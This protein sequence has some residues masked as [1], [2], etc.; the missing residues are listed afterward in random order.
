M[1]ANWPHSAQKYRAV[2][3]FLDIRFTPS[4]RRDRLAD[5]SGQNNDGQNIGQ[6]V[7][8]LEK[9]PGFN[10]FVI[11]ADQFRVIICQHYVLPERSLM[12][13]PGYDT[14][15]LISGIQAV[16]KQVSGVRRELPGFPA[17]YGN[18]IIRIP[19]ELCKY[20]K[21]SQGIIG[22]QPVSVPA[23]LGLKLSSQEQEGDNKYPVHKL[24]IKLRQEYFNYRSKNDYSASRKR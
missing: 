3:A 24:K 2:L 18:R 21:D 14:S 15:R 1:G 4:A 23:F 11:K 6:G 13:I 8:D 16:V 20:K 9:T 19:C 22:R 17:P 12:I 5:K 7:H 10:S